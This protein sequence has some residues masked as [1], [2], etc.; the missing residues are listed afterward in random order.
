MNAGPFF[1]GEPWQAQ[2][3]ALMATRSGIK[4]K[5]LLSKFNQRARA[6]RLA[7]ARSKAEHSDDEWQNLM[8]RL[9]HRC[10]MCGACGDGV[11]L[12]KDHIKPIYQGG[13]DGI[14]NLQPLCHKCN[15]AK[16]PDDFNWATYRLENGF[17]K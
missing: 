1:I 2:L 11:R 7:A 14:E 5:S 10:A 12:Q 6:I 8:D 4:G 13:S 17:Q 16:G 3:D 15:A 9:G